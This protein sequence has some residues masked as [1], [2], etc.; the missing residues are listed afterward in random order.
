MLCL[1]SSFHRKH[2]VSFVLLRRLSMDRNQNSPNW[3]RTVDFCP[4]YA[5]KTAKHFLMLAAGSDESGI[6]YSYSSFYINSH[7]KKI[8]VHILFPTFSGTLSPL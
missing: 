4:C 5:R 1:D 6:T 8:L 2:V 7:S 3:V